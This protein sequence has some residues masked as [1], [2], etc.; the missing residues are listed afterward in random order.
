MIRI[1]FFA[2]VS[3]TFMSFTE[4]ENKE[5]LTELQLKFIKEN[6]NWKSEEILIINFLQPRENCFWNNNEHSNS[7]IKWWEKFYSN[8]NLTN[9]SNIYVYSDKISA[10]KIID[11][12]TRFE[13]YNNFLLNNFFNIKKECFG[14]LVINSLGEYEF[15]EGEY[16][17]KQVENLIENLRR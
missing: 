12:K 15:I 9:I 6:Y 11:S 3:S 1:L 10:K 13:D 8:I 2:I 4:F 5:I 17:E 16:T 7:S 14:V